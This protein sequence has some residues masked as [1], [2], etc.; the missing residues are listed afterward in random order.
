[1]NT[2]GG[3]GDRMQAPGLGESQQQILGVLKRGGPTTVPRLARALSLNVETLR[4]HLK[5]LA[6][7]R[8]VERRSSV[9][10]GRGRP[11]IV[12]GLTAEAEA[13]FPRREGE[14]LKGFASY[15]KERGHAALLRDYLERTMEVR[16]EEALARVRGL[17]GRARL[18]EVARILSE[19]G[20]MAVVE[21]AGEASTLRLCHCPIRE[22][23]EETK[24]PCRLEQGFVAELVG[25]RLLRQS[26][27][28]AGDASC[29]YRG[30]ADGTARAAVTGRGPRLDAL[31]EGEV[32]STGDGEN[33]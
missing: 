6:G 13:L 15:L 12:Y 22:L 16:R 1:M 3:S 11:E 29:S 9:R 33:S 28:P 18:D 31:G 10:G 2:T 5:T 25:E 26:Y 27:I 30:V 14:L 24:L 20:F 17:K 8:L 32:L 4:A 7:H 23:I 19:L 21:G